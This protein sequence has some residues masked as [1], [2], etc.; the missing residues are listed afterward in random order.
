MTSYDQYPATDVQPKTGV[1]GDSAYPANAYQRQAQ[2]RR[3]STSKPQPQYPQ[4]YPAP[5]DA[6]PQQTLDPAQP[7]NNAPPRTNGTGTSTSR[8]R[9]EPAGSGRSPADYPPPAVP[10]VPRAPPVSFRD[11]YDPTSPSTYARD[12]S[13]SF[14]ARAGG[15][16]GEENA[17]AP[18][19]STGYPPEGIPNQS[20]RRSTGRG[21]AAVQPP[22]NARSNRQSSAP[23]V[24]SEARRASESTSRRVDTSGLPIRSNTLKDQSNGDWAADRSPLQKLEVTFNDISKEEKRARVEEAEMV[25]REAKTGRGGS[26]RVARDSASTAQANASSQGPRVLE[27]APDIVPGR[28]RDE[29][30]RNSADQSMEA[31][32]RQL[33]DVRDQR[34]QAYPRT[35]ATTAQVQ[36]QRSDARRNRVVSQAPNYQPQEATREAVESSRAAPQATRQRQSADRGQRQSGDYGQRQYADGLPPRQEVNSSH[37]ATLAGGAVAAAGTAAAVERSNSRKLQKAPP[38]DYNSPKDQKTD[39]KPGK[40]V[41]M[42]QQQLYA[43]K[44]DKTQAIG[45]PDPVSKRAVRNSLGAPVKY[46]IPPQTAGGQAARREVLDNVA[47]TTQQPPAQAGDARGHGE[48]K[49]HVSDLFHRHHN[50]QSVPV[51]Q[52]GANAGVVEEWRHG[53]FARL[54]GPDLDL[55]DDPANNAWWERGG[56]K[57]RRQ[58]GGR[59]RE[60]HDSWDDRGKATTLFEPPLFLKCGP[61][62]RYTGMRREQAAPLGTRGAQSTIEREMWRG[63]VMIVTEDSDSSYETPPTLRLFAQPMDLLPPPPEHVGGEDGQQLDPQHIDPI[64][65]LTTVSRIGKTLHIRPVDSL[66]E[67]VDLSQLETDDGLF[68]ETPPNLNEPDQAYNNRRMEGRDGDQMGKYKDVVGVRLYTDPARDVTFWRFNLEVELGPRQARIAYRINRGPAIG[69]WVPA[70]GESFNIMFHSCNG[71]SLSVKPD[72]FSGP[73]PLW[74]DVLNAHQTRPF[75]VM[76]GGGDQIYNDAVTT[77]PNTRLFQDWLAIKNPHEKHSYPFS[78]ELRDELETFYLNRYAMWFSQGLFGVASS[79]IPMVNMWDDHDIID[80]FGSYPHHFMSTPVF[81]GI[82]TIAFKYYML[83]QHQSVPA[84]TEVDEPSWLLGASPGPY[85]NERSRSLFMNFGRDIA[86]L[87]LDCRT[88]RMRDEIL[89]EQSYKLAFDRCERE[90]VKGQTKHLI[91]LL[92]VPI[93]YP[94]LVW[95]ENLLTSRVMDPVKALGRTGLL[96]GF[97]NKFDGGVEILDDLDDHWT[98]KNHKDERNW[99]IEELQW[100]AAEKSVRITILGGDV[101]LAAIGQFYSNPK[102][103]IPKDK[104]HRYMPNVISSAIVNTPPPELMG[105]VLN[106]R[107]KTHHLDEDT[108]EDM[109]PMFTHDTDGRPRNNKRLLPRRNWCSIREY[110]P[111][112]LQLFLCHHI[113]LTP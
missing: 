32:P 112:E 43:Q 82:G 16:P 98:A 51:E 77:N 41:P 103:K 91:V 31:E 93:A 12:P 83:F 24:E 15:L 87:A 46:D 4:N 86:F 26:R 60:S 94:R 50:R 107:N 69:F 101:H 25:L 11:P 36:S 14:S 21:V 8:R 65:G 42:Q 67:G 106:K 96:G 23:N 18:P 113:I 39:D 10:D 44:T 84:E 35:G 90:L 48:R 64:A 29:R 47:A 2:S 55:S 110:H 71:F 63:S 1:P 99:F 7:L 111:G 17:Y 5:A 9:R 81:S 45:E 59:V 40:S 102:L 92:G 49:H 66:R 54:V 68:Q 28:R 100:L 88:E 52:P 38:A 74:R 34:R 97:L 89:S 56:S 108:Y 57:K 19:Q 80:G 76:L 105:D 22:S 75:H 20:R 95:L 79:Q 61:L 3:R 72:D 33:Q 104:D 13:R 37:K 78:Q 53:G 85:I 58:S 109:I 6:M 73:D 62:L 70:S 30:I 27:K